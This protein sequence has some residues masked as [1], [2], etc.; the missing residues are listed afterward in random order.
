MVEE[1]KIGLHD[2]MSFANFFDSAALRTKSKLLLEEGKHD[3]VNNPE[4]MTM[5]IA[6]SILW[7]SLPRAMISP[8]R[9]L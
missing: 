3:F 2:L 4:A 8:G 5:S 1:D 9:D 7:I 6:E